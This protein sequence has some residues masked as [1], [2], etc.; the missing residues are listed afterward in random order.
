MDYNLQTVMFM[1]M[2]SLKNDDYSKYLPLLLILLTYINKIIPF[3][4]ISEY[5]SSLRKKMSDVNVEINL[6]THIVPVTKGFSTVAISKAKYSKV[7]LAIIHYIT[8]NNLDDITSLTEVITNNSDLN[9][10]YYSNDDID[11]YMF[12]PLNSGKITVC[13]EPLIYCELRDVEFKTKDNDKKDDNKKTVN[14][15]TTTYNII[16]FKKKE[17]KKDMQE[18]INFREKC[19]KDYD[20]FLKNKS[21]D[22]EN[23]KIF[24][25]KGCEKSDD[26][27]L[28]LLFDE[29]PMIHNKDLKKNI[30][31]EEKDKLLSYIEPFKFNIDGTVHPE[32]ER[33]KK[34]GYPFKAGILLSGPPGTGKTSLVKAIPK[35]CNMD[36]IDIRLDLVKTNQ[37]FRKIFTTTVINNHELN[38]KQ[39]CYIIE[40][41][42]A[43]ENNVLCSR[44][45]NIT[46]NRNLEMNNNE[47]FQFSKILET[48]ESI[49][50]VMNKPQEDA[51]NLSCILN[52]LDGIIELY[53]VMIIITTNYPERIDSALIRPGRIDFKLELKLATKKTIKE[54]L[55][56][57][58][59]LSDIEL[60][61]YTEHMNINDYILSPA[62]VQ[63]YCFQNKNIKDCIN[64][65]MLECQKK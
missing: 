8:N 10:S 54:M 18:L 24:Q 65:I 57:V 1:A 23:L 36:I 49:V 14:S 56:F 46:S 47:L 29:S 7:F 12:I 31:F 5:I 40:D 44:E 34:C 62:E 19:L 26:N 61:K 58:Y 15:S 2:S 25:Y 4:D 22:T 37:E 33:Y 55:K 53:G 32:E 3:E 21:K 60:E 50:N 16:L 45:D 63:S 30:F 28:K 48:Q 9:L 39:K 27:K 43:F 11:E 35:A 64:R 20:T 51:L 17:N 6:G 52:V 42:D 41:C 38:D 13:K 59:S